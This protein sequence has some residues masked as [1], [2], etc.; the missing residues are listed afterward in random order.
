MALSKRL[1]F[2]ILRRDNHTC[3][4]CGSAAPTVRIVVDHVVPEALGGR[5]VPENLVACCE[6]CNS[7]KSSVLPNSPLVADVKQD[8]LR[9][10]RAL[11]SASQIMAAEVERAATYVQFFYDE[12]EIIDI[13]SFRSVRTIEWPND[14]EETIR[15]FYRYGLSAVDVVDAY[16]RADNASKVHW[17]AGWKYFCGV[18]W[19]KIRTLRDMAGQILSAE[20]GEP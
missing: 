7:G 11:E 16:Q 15:T 2:E 6:P 10:A 20:D 19:N 18:C 17:Q 1:R 13:G 8:A 14:W 12:A 5:S 4:Y 3:R 9:W